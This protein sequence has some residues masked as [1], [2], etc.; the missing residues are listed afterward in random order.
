MLFHHYDSD[1]A[2]IMRQNKSFTQEDPRLKQVC[3]H[4]QNILALVIHAGDVTGI[5]YFSLLAFLY[6]LYR[7]SV[8]RFSCFF[9]FLCHFSNETANIAKV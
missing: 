8:A 5:L 3:F 4:S 7:T 1:S 9:F 2:A 6:F